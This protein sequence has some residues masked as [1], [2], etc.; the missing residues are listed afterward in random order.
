MEAKGYSAATPRR[1]SL[2]VRG[3]QLAE[4][5]FATNRSVN[6]GVKKRP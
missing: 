3:E 2:L 4:E 1:S 5:F 6:F